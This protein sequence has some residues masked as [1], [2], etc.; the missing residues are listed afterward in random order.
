MLFEIS[1]GI[2]II[3]LAI[4][5]MRRFLLLY[6][7][8]LIT[9]YGYAQN[10]LRIFRITSL[11]TSFPDTAREKGRM[12][13]NVLYKTSDHYRDSSVLIITPKHLYAKRKVDMIFWFHG[14]NNNIDSAVARYELAKQF[15]ASKLN[16]VLVLAETAKDA[17]DSYGGKLEHEGVFNNLIHDLLNKLKKE[18]VISKNCKP[19]NIMLAG[20]SG[21]YKVMANILQNGNVPVREVI[22]FDALYAET[23]KFINWIRSGNKNRFINLYTDNG[24]T[25][26]ESKSMLTQLMKLNIKADKTEEKNITPQLIRKEKIIFIHSLNK[27][28]DIINSPD[29]FQ[30]FIENST[31]F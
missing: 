13:Q 8:L 27:H 15:A 6:F 22:L 1:L 3:V 18:E 7:F 30:L 14:W 16:A 2:S 20:H 29:N 21:A 31:I 25:D 28:N 17:P 19:G 5:K 9:S 10:D 12:Y 24:G 23:D 26:E 11:F 4:F